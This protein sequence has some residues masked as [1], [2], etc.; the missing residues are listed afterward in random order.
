MLVEIDLLSAIQSACEIFEPVAEEKD[1]TISLS[2]TGNS[3]KQGAFAM[4]G[5]KNLLMQMTVHVLENAIGH[6]PAG[7]N[8][9]VNAALKGDTISMTVCDN[10]VGVPANERE[11]VFDRLYRLEESRTT[12]GAGVGLSFVKAIVELHGG[13]VELSDN[14]P[15]LCIDISFDS[16]STLSS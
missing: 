13:T 9:D 8:I 15:G 12:K 3:G 10:G 4:L 5:D 14:M 2:V 1:Q 6:C 16:H 7:S 11:R